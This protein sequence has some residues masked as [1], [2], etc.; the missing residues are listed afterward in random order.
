MSDIIAQAYDEMELYE[1]MCR[2]PGEFA[3]DAIKRRIDTPDKL[4]DFF[5]TPDVEGAK[6]FDP[7]KAHINSIIR[8]FTVDDMLNKIEIKF[9]SKLFGW[10]D[11]SNKSRFLDE[12]KD[13]LPIDFIF[14]LSDKKNIDEMIYVLDRILTGP[15]EPTISQ[16]TSILNRVDATCFQRLADKVLKDNRPLIRS[17]ILSAYGNFKLVSDHQKMIALKAFAK[18]PSSIDGSR[19]IQPI[20]FK[21]FQSL[22]PLE[23]LMALDRYLNYFRSSKRVFDPAPSRE[24]FDAILFAGC[25][26]F[27]DLVENI[28]KKYKVITETNDRQNESTN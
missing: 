5:T 23:R 22:K 16:I 27:N 12:G 2:L 15:V 14:N 24:E 19:H 25:F 20:D 28:T 1:V 18:I 13:K 17:S 26:E 8:N 3:L 11:K 10:L 4:M 9:Y 7:V 6:K 21:L